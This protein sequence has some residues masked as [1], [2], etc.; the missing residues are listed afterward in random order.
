MSVCADLCVG[1]GCKF[2]RDFQRMG[3]GEKPEIMS[4]FS[5]E[6]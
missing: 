6:Q 4:G 5:D 1:F 3:V 2:C